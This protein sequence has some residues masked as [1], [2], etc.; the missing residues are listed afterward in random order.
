MCLCDLILTTFLRSK[1]RGT[2]SPSR[3]AQGNGGPKKNHANHE[4]TR[5]GTRRGER[6]REQHIAAADRSGSERAGAQEPEQRSEA[7]RRGATAAMPQDPPYS[8]FRNIGVKSH[9][10][11]FFA[12][13]GERENGSPFVA[14]VQ[15][16]FPLKL[17]CL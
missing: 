5:A 1:G 11:L 3:I 8:I 7:T 10:I 2:W 6:W 14:G 15:A 16:A 4:I 17:M 12:G 9:F 13:F